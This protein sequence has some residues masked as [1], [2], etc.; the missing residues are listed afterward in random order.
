MEVNNIHQRRLIDLLDYSLFKIETVIF[1]LFLC[2]GRLDREDSCYQ[3][4]ESV[5]VFFLFLRPAVIEQDFLCLTS[6]F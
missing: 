6:Y 1:Q 3:M 2:N 5:N 4:S